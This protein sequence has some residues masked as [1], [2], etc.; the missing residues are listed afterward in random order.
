MRRKTVSDCGCRQLNMWHQKR[1]GPTLQGNPAAK[2]PP[3][4]T[5][6]CAKLPGAAR[7]E[8]HI[9]SWNSWWTAKRVSIFR[10]RKREALAVGERTMPCGENPPHSDIKKESL[11]W[12]MASE[13]QVLNFFPARMLVILLVEPIRAAPADVKKLKEQ[14]F[15]DLWDIFYPPK[16]TH[17]HKVAHTHLYITE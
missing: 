4:T 1:P 11:E 6:S 2:G 9:F 13:S 16:H 15:S 10:E 17:M 3:Y 7:R 8:Q 5:R 14:R 12:Q